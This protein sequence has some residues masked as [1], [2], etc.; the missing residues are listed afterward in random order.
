MRAWTVKPLRDLAD[1]CLGKMLDQ[2]K[3]KGELLPYLANVNVRWGEFDLA[4]LREMRFE[5]SEMARYGLEAGDI[6]MCEGGEPGR[7]AFWKDARSGMMLQ[8][9]LHRIRAK[10]SVDPRFLYYALL[11]KGKTGAFAPLFTGATIKHFPA[12]KLATVE[13]AFPPLPGQTKIAESLSAY[14]DLIENNRR[15]MAHLE[16][17][18]QHLF[19]EWFVRLRFPGHE[20]TKIT[21]GVPEG[22]TL[23]TLADCVTFRSGGTPAKSRPEF[24][25]G[26]IPWVSS[27]EMA[28][29]RVY[30]TSL[31][32]TED[33][34]DAG[35]RLVSANTILA[36]VRG[37]SLAKEFRIAMVARAM[38][39]NQDLKALECREG[40]SP[41]FLFHSLLDR[42]DMIRDLAGEAAHGTK[43]L[44]TTVLERLPVLLPREHLQRLFVEAV[45][46]M[47][48]QRDNLHQ[49]NVKLQTAR[50]LLLPRLMSGELTV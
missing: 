19:R 15:R 36:V 24:W 13:V 32:V 10:S 30:D 3:N 9:A 23:R 5:W 25:E 11:H 20:H 39:F 6:V 44:E 49:Q 27:G 16:D 40:V 47:V 45:E 35:S 46:P 29:T 7:C 33:G 22:W 14:D 48:A 12:E 26:D 34:V 41:L 21:Q 2:N 8:K 18:A 38:A 43:K 31:H 4:G 1:L 28:E 37:M 17:A 50:N 42:R